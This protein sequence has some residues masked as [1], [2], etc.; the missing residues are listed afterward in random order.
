[1]FF[2][3]NRNIFSDKLGNKNLG[4]ISKKLLKYCQQLNIDDINFHPTIK[5]IEQ[6]NLIKCFNTVDLM[7]YNKMIMIKKV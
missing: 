5:D 2:I 1:M 6:F 3:F 7:K 4:R